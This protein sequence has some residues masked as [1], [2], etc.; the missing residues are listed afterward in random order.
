MTEIALTHIGGPTVLLEIDGWRVLTDPT[1][2]PPG[3]RYR[4]GWGA[5]ST[6]LLGPA[7]T[8]DELP[9]IDVVLLTHDHHADNLDDTGRKLLGSAGRVVTTTSGAGRLGDSAE[10]LP[11]WQ[12]LVFDR[13]GDSPVTV[14]ATPCRHGPPGSHSIVGDV[15]GFALAWEGQQHGQL[16][17]TGD[18]VVYRELRAVPERL[19]VGTVVL[20]LGGVRFPITGPLGYTMTAEQSIPLLTELDPTT[21]VP[22]HY[23]GWSHFHQQR[24]AAEIAFRAAPPELGER[25]RWVEQGQ[26]TR[27]SV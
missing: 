2:D 4:F 15:I 9:P 3:R 8:V 23:D 21:V 27:L 5:A 1:F 25:I 11:P 20:H 26:P 16:W 22:V 6:K 19:D 10:G 18:T 12:Q 24:A 14:T 7:L 13:A 17:I